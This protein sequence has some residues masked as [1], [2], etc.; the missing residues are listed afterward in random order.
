MAGSRLHLSP[1]ALFEQLLGYFPKP[2]S[3]LGKK[4]L[5]TVA[6]RA[7]KRCV[8]V[9]SSCPWCLQLSCCCPS[10]VMSSSGLSV[11]LLLS[12]SLRCFPRQG[13]GP[14][15]KKRLTLILATKLL[16]SSSGFSG[17]CPLFSEVCP[18]FFGSTGPDPTTQALLGPR[19]QHGLAGWPCPH[20]PS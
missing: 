2:G 7:P 5:A 14:R 15:P 1:L 12:C 10:L 8:R 16:W 13:L 9:L 17:V 19:T 20:H 18:L 3:L 4:E 11:V 6:G